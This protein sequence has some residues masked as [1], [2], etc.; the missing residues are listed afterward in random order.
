[1]HIG[2]GTVLRG[3]MATAGVAGDA[4]S[5]EYAGEPWRFESASQGV[6]PASPDATEL[7]GGW[8]IRV[9]CTEM[10]CVRDVGGFKSAL[11]RLPQLP[12]C[13]YVSAVGAAGRSESWTEITS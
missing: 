4:K 13:A 5:N 6:I 3:A 10:G 7:P 11:N 2:R 1:M 12:H 8:S 9:F